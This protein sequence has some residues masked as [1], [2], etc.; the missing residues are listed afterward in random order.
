MVLPMRAQVKKADAIMTVEKLHFDNGRLRGEASI[1]YNQPWPCPNGHSGMDVP[2]GVLGVIMH[3]MV[4]NLQG[5]ISVFNNPR[6]QASAHFAIDQSGHIHQFGPVT[7]W[8]AWAQA[9]GNMNYYSIEFADN[10]NPNHP[11]TDRQ[12]TAGAQVVEALSRHGVF[13]L[14]QANRPGN[15]GLGVHYMGG[16]SW[17][18]HSCPDLP[19]RHVRSHQRSE[20]LARARA[21][22]SGKQAAPAE[23][24]PR[25]ARHGNQVSDGQLSLHDLSQLQQVDSNPATMLR[26]TAEA[27]P[28]GEYEPD[29]A[30]YIDEV[31]NGDTADMGI[32]LDWF[33]QQSTRG[34][35]VNQTWHTDPS[36]H[37][38]DPQPL[39]KLAQHLR[40]DPHEMVRLSAEL[41][42]G[43]VFP[44]MIA[45]YLNGIFARSKAKLPANVKLYF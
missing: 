15:Q 19:P 1:S 7:G 30:K 33:Y 12:L 41:A 21:I 39:A 23:H 26:R 4:G 24:H 29:L 34:G 14:Q 38:E 43:K 22:R 11:L 8:V 10:G 16:I 5:T 17:G 35:L 37:P 44:R 31:I 13:P 42:P 36:D 45:L 27:S 18:G 40:T 2:Q 28:N 3:T 25:P 9:D 20:M 6:Y 32:G